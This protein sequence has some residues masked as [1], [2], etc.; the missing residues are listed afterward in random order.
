M[1]EP[2]LRLTLVL[3]DALCTFLT[4][5]EDLFPDTWPVVLLFQ[6]TVSSSWTV[7]STVI[8]GQDDHGIL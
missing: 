8:M 5:S 4:M 1:A 3:Q 7:M 6:A 2:F